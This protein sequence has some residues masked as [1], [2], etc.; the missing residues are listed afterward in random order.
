MLRQASSPDRPAT[1]STTM[2]DMTRAVRPLSV[3]KPTKSVSGTTIR[4][5]QLRSVN[6]LTGSD[7]TMMR[8]LP[9]S[10]TLR[11]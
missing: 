8:R 11:P 1:I 10:R 7:E 5:T 6:M 3:T 9:K 4:T 2:T